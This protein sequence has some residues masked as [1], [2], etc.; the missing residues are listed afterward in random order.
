MPENS[1]DQGLWAGSCENVGLVALKKTHNVKRAK[2]CLYF[3]AKDSNSATWWITVMC[4]MV[5]KKNV[6]TMSGEK[7]FTSVGVKT[8]MQF[9][10]ANYQKEGNKTSQDLPSLLCHTN[11]FLFL[12]KVICF[13]FSFDGLVQALFRHCQ[14]FKAPI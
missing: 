11:I 5:Q 4:I 10:S 2:V 6:M 14:C 3:T 9:C 12:K 13:L 1:H 8:K 7:M